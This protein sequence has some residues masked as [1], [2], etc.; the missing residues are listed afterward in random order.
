MASFFFVFT[1]SFHPQ[2]SLHQP[3]SS[4]SLQTKY[5]LPMSNVRVSEA[6]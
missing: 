2:M 5:E 4:A 3:F 1:I 6:S